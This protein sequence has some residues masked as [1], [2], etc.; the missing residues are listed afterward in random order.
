MKFYLIGLLLSFAII[1]YE[2]YTAPLMD[3]SG[4]IIKEGRKLKDLF[5]RK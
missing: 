5:K 4:R 2:I 1:A 3:E